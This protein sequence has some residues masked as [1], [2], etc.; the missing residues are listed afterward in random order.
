[1]TKFISR[2]LEV[3][4]GKESS[5]GVA[6]TISY[7]LPKIN[8]T[9]DER[10]NNVRSNASAGAIAGDST[11]FVTERWAEGEL[12]AELGDKFFGLV[13]L[14]A[15]GTDTPTNLETTAYK[16][17]YALDNDNSHQSLTLAY[18]DPDRQ[19]LF[20]LGMINK[21]TLDVKLDEIVKFTAE[22]V[23]KKG[24]STSG[25]TPAYTAPSNRFTSKHVTLKIADSVAGLDAASAISIRSLKLVIEK[26]LSKDKVLG[27]LEPEDILNTVMRITGTVELNLNED[28]YR[29]YSLNGSIK[30]MRITM[31]NSDRTIGALNNPKFLID[32]SKVQFFEWERV[33]GL[34]DIVGQTLNFV[35][36][37]DSVNGKLWNDC[38]LQNEVASY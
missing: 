16:H 6:G 23:S 28:T 38:H 13:L 24:M 4:I 1:M 21:L 12:E 37:Y 19:L 14:A 3:G 32:F 25:L 15:L 18:K 31:L 22:L 8:F 30:A 5:R 20:R 7:W 11:G 17:T 27:S 34:D 9:F 35:V 33:G 26:N 2:L 36:Y 10:S 29:D